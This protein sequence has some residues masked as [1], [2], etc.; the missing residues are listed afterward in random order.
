MIDD[1]IEVLGEPPEPERTPYYELTE[2]GNA[3]RLVDASGHNMRY[4]PQLGRWF[5]WDGRRWEEDILGAGVRAAKAVSDELMHEAARLADQTIFKWGKASQKNAG[6]TSML[7]LAST[8]PGIGVL[9]GALDPDPF[10][11]AAANGTIDLR[12]G[13]L[14]PHDRADLITRITPVAYDPDAT[15]PTWDRFLDEVFD[16]DE[17]LIAFV[18]RMTGYSLT[19]DV[20]EQVMV[21]AHGSGR[22]GKTT[23]LNTL[24]HVCGDYGIQLDPTILVNEA[25][26]QHPT[27]LTDLRGARFVATVETEQGRRLNESLVK[28]LT[29]GDPIRA[30]RMRQDFFEF[31]PTHK[32]WFAGNHLPRISGTDVGIWRRLALVPFHVEFGPGKADK[33]L[34][35]Q[36]AEESAGILA[37]AVRGCLEWRRVGLG[38]PASVTDAT[39]AYR[40]SQDHLGRFL[41]DH[42]VV[43]ETAYV[44]SGD[45][46]AVYERWCGEQGERPWTAQAL[47]REL[48]SRGFEQTMVG[49]GGDRKRAWSGVGLIAPNRVDTSTSEEG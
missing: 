42:C 9:I 25:H 30:R 41:D 44:T 1:L 26:D 2:L 38:I 18:A 35:A 34:P 31:N 13:S 4:V 15:C 16:G 6:I 14:G 3:R 28:Q 11:M 45:L 37:W 21:F 24:R 17:E 27:G 29:G 19:G 43:A 8:E 23:L 39:T 20:S 22:N 10:L 48:T 46:R 49:S 33:T 36:L 5:A 12:D 40:Q 7:T 32:L 47:G